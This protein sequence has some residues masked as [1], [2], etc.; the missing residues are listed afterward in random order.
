MCERFGTLPEVLSRQKRVPFVP[1]ALTSARRASIRFL[2]WGEE[3]HRDVDGNGRQ[4]R[5]ARVWS[6]RHAP[7]AFKLRAFNQSRETIL[8]SVQSSR[9]RRSLCR[10]RRHLLVS[11]LH[12]LGAD[13]RLRLRLLPAPFCRATSLSIRCTKAQTCTIH[14]AVAVARRNRR[15]LLRGRP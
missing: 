12:P 2:S 15:H 8:N 9:L 6:F 3:P 14:H 5:G 4:G 13:A 10:C 1:A 7:R 11:H